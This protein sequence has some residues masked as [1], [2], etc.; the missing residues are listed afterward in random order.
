MSALPPEGTTILLADDDELLRELDELSNAVIP[1]LEFNGVARIVPL[2]QAG[3]PA[4]NLI[5]FNYPAW[6]T[7][8]DTPAQ[9]SSESL[10]IIG[11]V[12]LETLRQLP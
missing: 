11:D 12:L 8:R 5:D 10:G 4:V 7:T 9:C 6:H 2:I 1:E 3:I